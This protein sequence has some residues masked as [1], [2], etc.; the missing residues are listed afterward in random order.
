MRSDV[1]PDRPDSL[2]DQISEAL[3]NI[4][5]ATALHAFGSL[6]DG[7]ADR[8][9][10]IDLELVTTDLDAAVNARHAI[11]AQV[12]PLDLEWRIHPGRSDFAATLQFRNASLYRKVDIGFTRHADDGA[13]VPEGPHELLWRQDPAP[14]LLPSTVPSSYAPE[15]GTPA[16]FVA[17]QLLG[18][19][20]YVKGRKR[21]QHLT[22]YRFASALATAVLS[23]RYARETGDHS[24]LGGALSTSTWLTMDET[25]G[26]D[27]RQ[28][29]LA[30]LDYANPERM[31]RTVLRL[32]DRM[33][34]LHDGIA[35]DDPLPASLA[36]RYDRFVRDELCL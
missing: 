36:H 6:A 18:I 32:M 35:N 28:A 2:R 9:S 14:A 15:V 33:V 26:S 12:G 13:I 7:R 4:P 10:D 30:D 17:G 34:S 8:F 21:G 5:G 1:P 29:W 16:H 25:L 31:D 23:L 19:T 22:A 27:D 24:H 3:R 20:R 11:W